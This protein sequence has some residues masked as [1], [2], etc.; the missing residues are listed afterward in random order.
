MS[1]I[2]FVI[3]LLKLDK[4][5]GVCVWVMEVNKASQAPK[6]INLKKSPSHRAFIQTINKSLGN[7]RN[8]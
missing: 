7:G 1:V 3:Y 8:A 4:V 2:D 6:K 5:I